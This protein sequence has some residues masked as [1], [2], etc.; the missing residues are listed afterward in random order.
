MA[1]TYA[2]I[3]LISGNVAGDF[4][5]RLEALMCLRRALEEHGVEAITELGL[6]EVNDGQQQ[7]IAMQDELVRLVTALD[8]PASRSAP[9]PR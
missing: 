6:M 1:A 2:L 7:L 8:A 5:S 9:V 3:E 4:E